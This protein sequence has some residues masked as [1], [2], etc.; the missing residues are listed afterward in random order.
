MF[1]SHTRR[2]DRRQRGS[3]EA[4]GSSSTKALV[5]KNTDQTGALASPKGIEAP[6]PADRL[7]TRSHKTQSHAVLGRE[8]D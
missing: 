5:P 1:L 2:E 7:A 4:R 6:A 8:T 3:S